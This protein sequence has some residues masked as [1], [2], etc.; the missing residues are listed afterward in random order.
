MELR[1]FDELLDRLRLDELLR[2]LDERLLL[3]LLF[4]RLDPTFE[5][6]LV[7][8]VDRLRVPDPCPVA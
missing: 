3:C 4:P 8:R 2:E 5:P 6:R 7:C 1:D